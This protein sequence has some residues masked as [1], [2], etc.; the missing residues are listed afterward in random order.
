MRFAPKRRATFRHLS[1]Q[2]WSENVVL[3]AFWLANVLRATAP[4]DFSTSKLQKWLRSWSVLCILTHKCASRHSSVPFFQI[5]T[6]KMAP[7]VWCFVHFDLK[8]RF[9]PQWRGIFQ[10]SAEELPRW[11]AT[12][13]PRHFCE[14][15]FSNIRNHESLKK[16]QPFASFLTFC[17]CV[18]WIYWL[19][20]RVDL[21]SSDS[22]GVLI[23]FLLTWLLCDSAFQLSILSE[24]RLLNFLRQVIL[25]CKRSHCVGISLQLHTNWFARVSKC[26]SA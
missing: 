16:T 26:S 22:A 6:S 9:A 17:A 1:F 24:L 2:K 13:A 11:R 20:S 18:S 7:R 23:F 19:Y 3:C 15:Y 10:V 14:A 4:C 8:M 25:V 12:S 21:L 5:G